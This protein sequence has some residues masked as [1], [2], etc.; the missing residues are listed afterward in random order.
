MRRTILR[1]S[2]RAVARRPQPWHLGS[3][4]SADTIRHDASAGYR[5]T[6]RRARPYRH[7]RCN[8]LTRPHR[9][10]YWRQVALS[11]TRFNC[12]LVAAYGLHFHSIEVHGTRCP[13]RPQCRIVA[14]PRRQGAVRGP[15]LSDCAGLRMSATSCRHACGKAPELGGH[16]AHAHAQ[17][18][19][20][21][22]RP[23]CR[24]LGDL[25]WSRPNCGNESPPGP[26]GTAVIRKDSL[27]RTSA[28]ANSKDAK[29]GVVE[30]HLARASV[31]GR[32]PI[33][34]GFWL[35]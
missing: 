5:R 16:Q 7:A 29:H 32:L 18:P 2:G 27:A 35:S 22:Y 11:P 34:L 3:A 12:D 19:L 15:Q 23:L 31:P 4:S 24:Q 13:T 6:N 8:K 28:T 33:H 1:N 20:A 14:L 9:Y 10:M 30:A 17:G 25:G 21:R 26:P